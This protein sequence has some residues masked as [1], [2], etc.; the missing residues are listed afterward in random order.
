MSVVICWLSCRWNQFL[1]LFLFVIFIR[2]FFLRERN[3][4]IGN[5][6]V[7]SK[8]VTSKHNNVIDLNKN[9][10]KLY[11]LHHAYWFNCLDSTSNEYQLFSRIKKH[12]TSNLNAKT[13]AKESKSFRYFQCSKCHQRKLYNEQNIKIKEQKRYAELKLLTSMNNYN[14]NKHTTTWH[15]D[16][17]W[18]RIDSFETRFNASLFISDIHAAFCDSKI[19]Y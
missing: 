6:I 7:W 12:T 3:K 9:R 17:V 14:N 8:N 4:L 13:L 15:S 19:T 2:F 10:T 11:I 16:G 5:S 18:V 1:M